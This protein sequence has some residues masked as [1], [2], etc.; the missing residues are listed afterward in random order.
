MALIE[1]F[2]QIGTPWE[3][4]DVPEGVGYSTE[5]LL[6]AGAYV[7]SLPTHAVVVVVNGKI[8]CEYGNTIDQSYIAS[9]RKSVLS[10]LYGNYVANGTI[11]LDLTLADLGMDDVQGLLPVEKLATVR[12]LITARSGV[13]HPASNSGDNPDKPPRGSKKPGDHFLYN[14]WDFNAAGTVFEKLTGLRIYDAL[15]KDL[16]QPLGFEHWNRDF[17][18]KNGDTSRSLNEAYHMI[19]STRDM[20]R[21][22]ELMLQEGSW[23]GNQLIP[24]SW[25]KCITSVTT[26]NSE[27]NSQDQ[28]DS[29]FGYGYMWWVWDGEK[30]R[31][32]FNGAYA[33]LGYNGQ[34]M[35]IIPLLKMVI[36]HKNHPRGQGTSWSEY[37][38]ILSRLNAARIVR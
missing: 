3:F 21:L 27:L 23:E 26:P 32:P 16:A 25:V 12:D 30:V 4:H 15:G 20:A 11:D 19:F 24:K 37:L 29:E 2:D 31:Y 8:L 22:G 28:Q 36:A 10:M 18:R 9:I 14:N 33:A 7:D 6:E 17:H 34:Y 38:G 5:R 13:Y 1:S 35:T